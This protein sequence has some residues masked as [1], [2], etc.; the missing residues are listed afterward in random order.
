[1]SLAGSDNSVTPPLAPLTGIKVVEFGAI[2]P[3]PFAAMMLADMGA[4]VVRIA[5]PGSTF[6]AKADVVLRGRRFISLDLKQSHEKNT[7]L[8]LCRACD[9]LLE[10]YRPGVMERLGLGPDICTTANPKL[11]YGRMTGWGQAGPLSTTPG[12]D[13][14]FI[15]L[16]GALHAIGNAGGPPV[17]PLNLLGDYGGG[18]MLLA[19]GVVCALLEVRRSGLGQVIDAAMVDGIASLMTQYCGQLGKGQWSARRGENLFDGGAPWYATYETADRKYVA[20]GAIEE[21]FWM[22][23]LSLLGID[24]SSL[25]AR[26]ERGAW[27]TIRNSLARQFLKRTRAEWIKVFEGSQACV[28]PVLDLAEVSDHPHMATRASFVVAN[29]ALQ[30]APVPRL[31][32]TPGRIRPATTG[33]GVLEQIR[34]DWRLSQ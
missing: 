27:D 10:G 8:E 19:F 29:G 6:D 9:V 25:P 26:D 31:S 4:D 33:D 23:L 16:A 17:P 7:A 18:G 13:I 14:N 21:P 20:V 2:G 11:I 30:S 24:S 28:S 15:A 1:M 5:R 12:H 32:R 34:R 22:D 3:V